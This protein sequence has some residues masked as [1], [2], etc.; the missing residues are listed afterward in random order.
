MQ[1][2]EDPENRVQLEGKE[3]QRVLGAREV[4]ER[5]EKREERGGR[6]TK[7]SDGDG[8]KRE[9]EA[10][11]LAKVFAQLRGQSNRLD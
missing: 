1:L 10:T 2:E 5:K 4:F 9:R 7:R 3:E 8:S 11:E 6:E